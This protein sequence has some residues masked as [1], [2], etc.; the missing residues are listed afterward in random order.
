MPKRSKA[1]TKKYN[2]DY[3][4]KHR[5]KCITDACQYQKDNPERTYAKNLW[6][7][8]R[9]TPEQKEY[10]FASQGFVCAVCG[11][12]EKPARGWHV[13]HNHETEKVRGVLCRHCNLMLGHARDNPTV[14]IAGAEY[15]RVHDG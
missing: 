3:Y 11:T 12:S 4:A 1:Q 9:I 6:H 7:K 13:D 5:E 15:L 8:Y 10:M 2:Q 14:L